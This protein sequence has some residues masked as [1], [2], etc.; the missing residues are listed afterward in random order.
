MPRPEAYGGLPQSLGKKDGNFILEDLDERIYH[1]VNRANSSTLKECLRSGAH[2]QQVKL[3]PKKS[4]AMQFGSLVHRMLEVP[5]WRSECAIMPTFGRKKSDQ[6]AKKKWLEDNEDRIMLT[7]EQLNALIRIERNVKEHPV[8]AAM[9]EN[10]RHE[11]SGFWEGQY[12]IKC[13]FRAD[14]LTQDNVLV[15]WKTCAD[16]TKFFYDAKRF[17][18]DLQAAFYL[19]G[20]SA[21][22]GT[23]QQDFIFVAIENVAPF[24]V[25]VY[26]LDQETIDKGKAKVEDAMRIYHLNKD[27]ENWDGYDTEIRTLT[28]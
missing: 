19:E 10:A 2:A 7:S 15:D 5:E 18:Y 11:A 24:G 6:E 20:L 3:W 21:I 14:M 17:K 27:R 4:Q 16:A 9:S 22:T 26:H 1:L 13:K 25:I 23:T 8:V 12:G 28:F